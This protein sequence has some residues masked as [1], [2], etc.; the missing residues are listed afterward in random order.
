M[1]FT[2]WPAEFAK[3][4]T[5]HINA[6]RTGLL[7][8]TP[9]RVLFHYTKLEVVRAIANSGTL[10][11]TCVADPGYQDKNEIS[12]GADLIG[13]EVRRTMRQ[14]LSAFS[15]L[16]LEGLTEGIASR[17]DR[18]FVACF[19]ANPDSRLHWNRYG[20]YRLTFETNRHGEPILRPPWGT[21]LQYHR[22]VYGL[23]RQRNAIRSAIRGALSALDLSVAGTPEGPWIDSFV[24]ITAKATAELLLDLIVAF[25]ERKYLSEKEWRLVV[26]PATPMFSTAPDFE[27]ARFDGRVKESERRYVE[28]QL[29]L[30]WPRNVIGGGL[31]TPPV[32]FTAVAQSP[33]SGSPSDLESIRN[34]LVECDRPDIPVTKVHQPFLILV[35]AAAHR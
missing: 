1:S 30:D 28:L 26:R 16:V 10:W 7:G 9:P 6:I 23:R 2:M 21:Y 13:D 14:E 25:K 20:S 17:K 33:H 12:L 11:A 19:C 4:L 27:D 22:V 24:D 18:T 32:P 35:R 15:R 31:R 34:I 8:T 3:D 5:E 29:A